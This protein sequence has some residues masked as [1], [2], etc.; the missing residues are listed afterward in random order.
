MYNLN[1]NDLF[2]YNAP[3]DKNTPLDIETLYNPKKIDRSRNK[4]KFDV[5]TLMNKNK[6]K[7]MEANSEYKK[8]FSQC[9][10]KITFANRINANDIV[11]NIPSKIY[12]IS[13]YNASICLKYIKKKLEEMYID[14]YI[15]SETSILISWK[16]I[17]ENRENSRS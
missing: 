3:N 6:D 15:T 12:R 17:A 13:E 5:E 10:D 2:D 16:N 8:L 7:K 9:L 1:I 14:V 4:N 11:F